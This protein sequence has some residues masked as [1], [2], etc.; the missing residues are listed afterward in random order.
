MVPY[1]PERQNHT[2]HHLRPATRDDGDAD[3]AVPFQQTK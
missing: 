3:V 1:L 2:H